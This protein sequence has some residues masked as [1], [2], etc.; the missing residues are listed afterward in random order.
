M[1][2]F[3][4]I[5]GSGMASLATILFD[6]GYEVAGSDIDKYIFIEDELR[7][8]DIPIYSF[9]KD[10]IKD[11]YDVIIGNAFDDSNEEVRAAKANP[12]VITHTYYDFLG[13]MMEDYISIGIA[14]THG[15]T[16]TTGMA[17]HLFKDY[18]KTSVLIGDGT[19]HAVKDSKYFIA[20]TCEYQ[21]HFL[22]YYPKYAV[23][24]NIELDHVD[25]FKTMDQYVASFEKYAN[26]VK[27]T[28]IIWGDDPYLPK[29]HYTKRV[30]KFGIK[31]NND[32]IAKNIINNDHGLS[33]D[34]YVHGDLFGH[35][36]LPF[37]GMH[38]LYDSLAV[39]T[40]GYL[41]NMDAD[42]IQKRLS[43]FEGVKRRYTVKEVGNNIYVDDYAHHPTAI[44]Y[45]IEAT[46]SRYPGREI[47]AIF[48]PDRFSRG[49]R[50]A[51]EFAQSLELADYPFLV[52]FPENAKKEP[53]IDI[54]IYEIAQYIPR[55]KVIHEDEDAVKL[56]ADHDHVVYIFMSSK[57]I[58][59][60]EDMVIAYKESH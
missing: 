9:N 43:T 26:Q 28:V 6:L 23:I 8:R 16:T 3:I 13:Q 54:D 11:G 7:K 45:V 37:Y 55:A 19:G 30:L 34:V 27:D 32:I 5:K 20:E 12:N 4:G 29:L 56:L 58:Y 22:H 15:K 49:L 33:F 41:E 51:K 50:F 40:L 25:Y 52:H 1:Y 21:D 36:A 18:D 2:Y 31:E 10:N 42:Y 46:R 57:D 38:M 14:G 35:F 59:K 60:L 53:G 24:N 39:I 48:Q 17:Y 44:R 47:V